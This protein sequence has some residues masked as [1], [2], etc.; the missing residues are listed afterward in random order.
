MVTCRSNRWVGCRL[1]I[2]FDIGLFREF[3]MGCI[4]V[5]L[6]YP[7]R[8]W[9]DLTRSRVLQARCC[10]REA[11]ETW[12]FLQSNID[13]DYGAVRLELRDAFEEGLIKSGIGTKLQEGAFRVGI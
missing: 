11:L 8:R 6:L 12:Q 10:A 9:A 1:H 3:A 2:C 13:L 5:S 7:V 4:L